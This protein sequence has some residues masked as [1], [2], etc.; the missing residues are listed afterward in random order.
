MQLED[1]AVQLVDWA[2][3]LVDEAAR[4]V[5]Y[6]EL[7]DEAVQLVDGPAQLADE[8]AQL[9]DKAVQLVDEGSQIGWPMNA[10]LKW[11]DRSEY[12][13]TF[14]VE[15][16]PFVKHSE[17]FLPLGFMSVAPPIA[18]FTMACIC[19]ASLTFDLR[20]SRMTSLGTP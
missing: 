2:V 19:S 7:V 16:W 5:D 10:D 17:G 14:F 11:V 12:D 8:M 18:K 15:V 9:V 1:G 4:L 20:I 6:A 3:Q 13:V